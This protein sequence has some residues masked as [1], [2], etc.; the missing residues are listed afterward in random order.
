VAG[1]KGNG[2][3]NSP[4]APLPRRPVFA[5]PMSPSNG[6]SPQPASALNPSGLHQAPEEKEMAESTSVPNFR[7]M[8]VFPSLRKSLGGNELK[9]ESSRRVCC[10][11]PRTA[12]VQMQRLRTDSSA[13]LRGPPCSVSAAGLSLERWALYSVAS[14]SRAWDFGIA[15]LR[16]L[17]LVIKQNVH[18]RTSNPLLSGHPQALYFHLCLSPKPSQPP[19]SPLEPQRGG[20]PASRLP[21]ARVWCRN[22]SVGVDRCLSCR[23]PCLASS[24]IGPASCC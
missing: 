8:I 5:G 12:L 17:G 13:A 22:H 4:Q 14:H 1:G 2:S 3:R 18:L 19:S 15:G 9:Q 10:C 11:M 20:H 6:Y 23:D 16:R 7:R 21:E 24:S